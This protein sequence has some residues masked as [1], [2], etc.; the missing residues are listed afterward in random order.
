MAEQPIKAWVDEVRFASWQNP[1]ELKQMFSSA[2]ILPNNRVVFNLAGNKYRL[3]TAILYQSQTV[4]IK[5][6]GT[7]SEYDKIDVQPV[8]VKERGA[9]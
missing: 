9:K 8:N 4:L 5:F 2:S 1:A 7:H 6:I 3:V